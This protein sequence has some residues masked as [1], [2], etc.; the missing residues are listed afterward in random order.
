M[1][2]IK[3]AHVKLFSTFASSPPGLL[4]TPFQLSLPVLHSYDFGKV[5]VCG[6]EG[7]GLHGW[8]GLNP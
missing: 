7:G 8:L 6:R 5:C 1:D 2:N 3:Y 4:A